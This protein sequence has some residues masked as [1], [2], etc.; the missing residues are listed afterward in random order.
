MS[1]AGSQRLT[2]RDALSY[3]RDIKDRFRDR[4]EIY[5]KFLEIMKEFKS[6]RI[7]TLGVIE[8][9]K[10]LFKGYPDLI[11]GFNT[12]LPKGYEIKV[13][14]TIERQPVEFDQAINYVNK[15]KHR[16]ARDERVYKAFLEILNTYRKGGKT[17]SAVYEEVSLLFKDHKDLLEEFAYFLPDTPRMHAGHG[18]GKG[19]TARLT[20][21][22][23]RAAGR[24]DR[25]DRKGLVSSKEIQFFEKVKNRVRSREIYQEFIKVLNLFANDVIN[26]DEMLC[27]IDD[28]LQRFPELRR[29]FYDLMARCDGTGDPN[30]RSTRAARERFQMREKYLTLPISEL[31]LSHCERCT[32]SYRML[33]DDY[34]R[35]VCSGRP[36]WAKSPLLNDTWVNVISGSEDYSF[37]LMRKNQY[38]ESLFR[39]EDDRYELDLVLEQNM[40]AIRA[41]KPLYEE[42][43]NMPQEDRNAW[44]LPKDAL[45]PVHL[46]MIQRIYNEQGHAVLELL[47]KNPGVSIPVIYQRLRQKDQEWRAVMDQM[48]P[49]WRKV[50]EANYHKSLDHRS[51]YFKQQDKKNLSG[52]AM[53]QE[54]R[55]SAERRHDHVLSLQYLSIA[56]PFSQRLQPDITLDYPHRAHLDDAWR[57]VHLGVRSIVSSPEMQAKILAF[58]TE[59]L[60]PFFHLGERGGDPMEE[61]PELYTMLEEAMEAEAAAREEKAARD[62]AEAQANGGAAEGGEGG[63]GGEGEGED[64]ENEKDGEGAREDE[65]E[66][67]TTGKD[68]DRDESDM[69]DAEGA[70]P[71]VDSDEEEEEDHAKYAWCRPLATTRQP[72]AAPVRPAEESSVLYMNSSLYVLL[73]YHYHLYERIAIARRCAVQKVTQRGQDMGWQEG[74][75]LPADAQEVY[76]KFLLL[77]AQLL[78]NK[79]DPSAFEDSARSLLGTSAYMVFTLDKLVQKTVKHL[80]TLQADEVTHKLVAL[81]RYERRRG[82]AASEQVYYTNAHVL[83]GEEMC[84]RAEHVA[85]ERKLTVQ[86]LEHDHT[87]VPTGVLDPAFAEYLDTFIG[88]VAADKSGAASTGAPE[89]RREGDDG[90]AEMAEDDKKSAGGEGG[91][92]KEDGSG[93]DATDAGKEQGDANDAEEDE[94]RSEEARQMV[95]PFLKRCLGEKRKRTPEELDTEAQRILDGA[96][97]YNGLE[98]KMACATYKVSYVLDTEDV[99]AVPKRRKVTAERAKELQTKRHTAFRA[100]VEGRVARVGAVAPS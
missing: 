64:G 16:F 19:A 89:S 24:D 25:D 71:A 50:F 79:L 27:L 52:K 82:E 38:E 35:M 28:V 93:K 86:L 13:E 3:L 96:L 59:F 66:K 69:E 53:V 18:R 5:D 67:E 91:E 21:P 97:L 98:C 14:D 44:S 51:F 36:E 83:L 94:A 84:F 72:G 45:T 76:D 63:E 2:T 46:R 74:D 39:C 57:I 85:A 99:L 8:R 11:L 100:W 34:P 95:Q 26:R 80:N 20:G 48:M 31:D 61:D 70:E 54:I 6:N 42:L 43:E 68:D 60:E 90:D 23:G 55:D 73:R 62:A 40:S 77:V 1:A 12:F 88:V 87:E 49:N 75:P 33:P 4:R 9:V 7:D 92:A 65:K 30:D 78:T 15:I 32:P 47:Y 10:L 58:W 29:E 56:S 41:M 37:K 22:R 17:I 81:H